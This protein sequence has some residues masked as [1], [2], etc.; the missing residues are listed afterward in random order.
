[1]ST[2]KIFSII[3]LICSLSACSTELQNE[4][5]VSHT[6][7]MPAKERLNRIEI[8]ASKD[9]VVSLLGLPS[10][11]NV[12]DQNS[13][14]YMSSDVK[15]VAFWAP[16]ETD[17]E[18]LH[19]T[20]NSENKIESLDVLTLNDGKNIKTNDNST[21]VKG[22]RPGFFRKYFGGVGQYTPFGGKGNHGL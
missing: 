1:M 2:N 4:W 6:G 21:E 11:V 7:N 18:I 17:R 16:K 14:V 8:G 15:K 3:A 12:F 19:I 22:Q 10:S 9:D 20:F 13:W 5:F